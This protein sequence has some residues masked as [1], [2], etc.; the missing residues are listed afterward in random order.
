M[1]TRRAHAPIAAAAGIQTLADRRTGPPPRFGRGQAN[2]ASGG[3]MSRRVR[4][5]AALSGLGRTAVRG[6]VLVLAFT[7]STGTAGRAADKLVLQLHRPGQFEFAGYYA[8][9]WQGF[10]RQAG[11]EVEIKAGA[12][13]G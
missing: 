9:L 13:P 12:A 2:T 7:V 5:S 1:L 11:F 10:Y 6:S 4:I 3:R 8:A